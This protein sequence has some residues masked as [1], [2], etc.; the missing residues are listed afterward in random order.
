MSNK[1]AFVN[2]YL[3]MEL[4]EYASGGVGAVKKVIAKVL[5]ARR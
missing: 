2:D 5:A 3:P 1:D 4:S